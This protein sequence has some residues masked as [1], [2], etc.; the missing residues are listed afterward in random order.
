M[1]TP[2]HNQQASPDSIASTRDANT[3]TRELTT[4]KPGSKPLNRSNPQKATETPLA[5]TA[6]VKKY[7][8]FTAVDKVSFAVQPGEIFGLLGPNG[9]GKTSIISCIVTLE[10]PT[11][12]SIEVFGEDVVRNPLAAK[13]KIGFVPQELIHHGYFTVDEILKFHA[14]YFGLLRNKERNDY[15]LN[16]LGLFE[17]RHKKV[18]GL[19]G[20]MKRR[21]LIAKALVHEPKL[22]LL[23]EPTAGVD[24]ELRESLWDFVKELQKSGTSILLTTHYL[25]EA[26]EL[27]SRVGILQDGQIKHMGETSRIVSEFTFRRVQIKLRKNIDFNH[28]EFS[29]PLLVHSNFSS[30]QTNPIGKDRVPQLEFDLP[31]TMPLGD[32]LVEMPFSLASIDDVH[33]S[34]G[35][36]EQALRTILRSDTSSVGSDPAAPREPSSDDEISMDKEVKFD[37]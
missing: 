20:G 14:G 13:Q 29:H 18:K 16:R 1:N 19:S 2:Q 34:E 31:M 7:G 10:S 36:L 11:A 35:S 12:G 5:I 32:F 28:R 30:V 24:I 15:L 3:S 37:S 9:A 23:D 27:C 8:A 4:A 33:V 6:L 26:E 17:H 22:L 21:L 25:E